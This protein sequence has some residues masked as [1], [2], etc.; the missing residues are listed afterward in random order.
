MEKEKYQVQIP[1]NVKTR[2]ELING[3]GIKEIIITA[4]AGAISTLIMIPVYFIILNYLICIIIIGIVTSFTFIIVMKDKNN[5]CIADLI[6]NI[7]KYLKGQRT[8][9]YVIKEK[10]TNENFNR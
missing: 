9:E 5:S 2:T 4:I 1:A 8:Y 3:I 7:Y 6:I 10:E